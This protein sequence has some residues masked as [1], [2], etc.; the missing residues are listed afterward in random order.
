MN[1]LQK[2]EQNW[3]LKCENRA[4]IGDLTL[5]L[6]FFLHF[7]ASVQFKMSLAAAALHSG[8]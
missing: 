3:S 1:C 4:I 8:L 6:D 5:F 7:V 2:I